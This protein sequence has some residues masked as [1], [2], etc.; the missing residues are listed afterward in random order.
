LEG[1]YPPSS[2]E[3][4]SPKADTEGVRLTQ[5]GVSMPA[6]LRVDPFDELSLLV[7]G[8]AHVDEVVVLAVSR[9]PVARCGQSRL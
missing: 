5:F 8:I 6:N 4:H 2:I 9:L 3:S 1:F 7:T